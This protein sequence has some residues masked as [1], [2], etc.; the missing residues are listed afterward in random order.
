MTASGSF[1]FNP[2][3]NYGATPAIT[4]WKLLDR[5][6]DKNGEWVHVKAATTIAQYDFVVIDKAG[7]ASALTTTLATSANVLIGVAQVAASANDLLFVWRGNGGGTG[8]GIKGNVLA[9]YVALA[10]LYTTATAT[11][12][13]ADDSATTLIK[14]VVGLTTDSGSGSA[15]ELQASSLINCN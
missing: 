15:V 6:Y 14:N 7:N 8:A 1:G 12:G 5:A 10:Q 9:S 3:K 4:L 11:A 2:N 13:K